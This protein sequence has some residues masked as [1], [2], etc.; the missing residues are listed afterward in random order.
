MCCSPVS[1]LSEMTPGIKRLPLKTAVSKWLLHTPVLLFS[2]LYGL[3]V[4]ALWVGIDFGTHWDEVIQYSLVVQSYQY[5][6]FL[7]HFYDYPAMI[8]WFDLASVADKLFAAYS[9]VVDR[10][11]FWS[12]VYRSMDT[13][14][15]HTIKPGELIDL[16]SPLTPREV[17]F[18]FRFFILRARVLVMLVSSLG[19]VWIFLA[20]RASNLARPVLA[21]AFGG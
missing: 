5:E 20:L 15:M 13:V 14:F 8:Y 9:T 19:G 18:D 3:T 16:L 10:G 6:L 12:R 17:P 2:A 4:Y 7:P 1:W 11:M 21:A